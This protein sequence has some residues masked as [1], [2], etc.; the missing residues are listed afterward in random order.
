[1]RT[2]VFSIFKVLA[3][4]FIISALTISCGKDNKS[5]GSSSSSTTPVTNPWGGQ[6][7]IGGFGSMTLP[8]DWLQRLYSEYPCRNNTNGAVTNRR[9]VMPIQ[10]QGSFQVNAGNLHV[11]VTVEGDILT[12]SNHNNVTKAEVHVCERPS[13]QN[14]AYLLDRPVLNVSDSC[15]MGEVT[16]ADVGISSQYGQYTLLFFPAGLSGPSSLCNNN[17]PVIY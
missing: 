12:I 10:S 16:A 9:I 3:M 11:G 17:T 8:G 4:T 2:R 13:L 6:S 1:M 14:T 7:G 15:A 5:G